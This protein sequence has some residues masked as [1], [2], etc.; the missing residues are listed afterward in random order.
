MN[1]PDMLTDVRRL[2]EARPPTGMQVDRFEIVDEV[3][4]LSLSFRQ[5]VLENMLAAE[6]AS[7]GGP[8]DWDDPRA[9]LEE[10]SPTWAYAAGIAALLHHGYFNQVILAQHE[11][12]LEQVLADHGRPGTP[13][14]AT[15]TYSPTDLMPYYRRLKT[16]HLQH[17][18]ASHD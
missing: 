9:P 6:L 10:G 2:I 3:A 15:A 14:T 11:R 7:T 4:E 12:D 16:A 13:V 5:D 8:S 17:L 1:T 18:S